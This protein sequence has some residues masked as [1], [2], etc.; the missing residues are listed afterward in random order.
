M[1]LAN[2][3]TL[4]TALFTG[5]AV[6]ISLLEHPARLP[7]P[8]AHAVGQWRLS[9][10]RATIMQ[11]SL[12]VAGSLLAVAARLSGFWPACFLAQWCHSR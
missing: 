4:A 5:A 2:L 1:L 11:A 8:P 7:C 10:K 12:A 6:Y 3:A 9:S